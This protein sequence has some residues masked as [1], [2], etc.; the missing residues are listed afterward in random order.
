M[1]PLGGA[2][3]GLLPRDELVGD[4]RGVGGG[5]VPC[6]NA[7]RARAT[8]LRDH[9]ADVMRRLRPVTERILARLPGPRVL[10]VAVWALVPWLNAGANLVLDTE[11]TSAVWE[12]S[13]ALVLL[14]YAA[15][16]LA[17]VITLWGSERIARRLEA[18]R[19]TT[20]KVLER[21]ASEPF[22]E[23]N[24]VVGPLIASAVTSTVF[25][26]GALVRDGGTAAMLRG[27]TWFVLG[28]AL[29]TFLWT[30]G[31]LQLGLDRL[32]REHLHA[33]ATRVDP[34]LGL[35][36]LGGIAFTGLWM[37]LAWL[38]P[39]LLT[40]LPDVGGVAIGVLV[41]TGLPDIVGAV[42]GLSLIGVGLAAFLF[43]MVRLHRRMIEV[44]DGELAVARELYAQAYAPLRESPTLDVL[45]R[46][47]NLLSAA[48]ALEKRANAIHDW[49]IDEATVARVLTITTSVTAISVAR[50]IL[51][52]LGL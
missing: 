46:Q 16:S 27:A 44:K 41:L 13:R 43:S 47:R 22:R 40:G 42:V 24:S 51:D 9:S 26:A 35:R 14:N 12:Q 19:A 28:I 7:I 36:P 25:A 45:E 52:P 18:L 23:I 1:P 39:I 33:D 37:L 48:D 5:H 34:S 31:S 29:W 30:Y 38:V 20:A 49:P 3:A 11:G 10:W 32:G 2:T 8:L 50:L 6:G 4:T 17:I 15:L 21:N